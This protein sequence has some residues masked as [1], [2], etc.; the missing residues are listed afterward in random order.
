MGHNASSLQQMMR[1][2]KS[3][4]QPARILELGDQDVVG[5]MPP[6]EALLEIHGGDETL[7]RQALANWQA[8]STRKASELFRNSHYYYRC[9]DLYP[10]EFTLVL[11][12]NDHVVSG[13]D[14]GN[15]DL[16]TNMGTTE[17]IGDQMNAFRAIHD[18]CAPG[19]LM[20]HNVPFS[21]YYNHG[22]YNYHPMF[23]IFLAHANNYEIDA[24]AL[25]APHFPYT[26]R[27]VECIPGSTA[28]SG[29]RIESG[30]VA[31]NLHK[32]TNAAFHKITDFDAAT[33]GQR[34]LRSPWAELVAERYDLRLSH[35]D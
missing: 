26:I 35:E 4:P 22:L 30:I 11:D 10:G 34:T 28:W 20:M 29:M 33:M 17:H 1:L 21:G 23:F 8:K 9:V 18:F 6:Y 16:I 31:C 5:D 2:A 25:S 32:I 12:L 27:P 24:L 14:Y 13:S 19:G 7:A 15:F 3:F